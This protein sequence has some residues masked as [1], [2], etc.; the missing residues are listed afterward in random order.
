MK[1]IVLLSQ[2][3]GCGKTTLADE[4]TCSLW[5]TGI[6]AECIDLDRQGG[7]MC[8]GIE[9]DNADV[10]VVDTAGAL[11]KNTP[12]IINGADVLVIPV[13]P[14]TKDIPAFQRTLMIIQKNKQ[15][16][17]KVIIVLNRATHWTNTRDFMEW[18]ESEDLE[19]E[20]VTV[21]Q[22]ELFMQASGANKS[23]VEFSPRSTAAAS[24]KNFVNTVRRAA[25]L[26]EE[27]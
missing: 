6:K 27:A 23:V 15:K 13:L 19:A 17:A 16:G 8:A 21:A 14:S 20:L 22:S 10:Q 24:V 9:D 4:I 12:A 1:T 26:P 7:S 3:G 25:E 5:R 11:S 2:K 18:L